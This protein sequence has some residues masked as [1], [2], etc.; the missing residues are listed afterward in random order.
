MSSH[1]LV[2]FVSSISN[3]RNSLKYSFYWPCSKTI[4]EILKILKKEGYIIHYQICTKKGKDFFEIFL[5]SGDRSGK[6]YRFKLISKPSLK[7]HFS[8]KDV[9]KFS[10][11]IGMFILSTPFGILSDRDAKLLG[12]GGKV[13]LYVY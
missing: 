10:N 11:N 8:R 5:K 2:N 7:K 6:Y 1:Q 4:L 3:V 13:L 12:T 9:W